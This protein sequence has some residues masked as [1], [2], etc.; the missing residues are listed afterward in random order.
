MALLG[1]VG[2]VCTNFSYCFVKGKFGVRPLG[3]S[4]KPFELE[5]QSSRETECR[6]KLKK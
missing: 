6:L 4:A 3:H 1:F 2:R 5:L